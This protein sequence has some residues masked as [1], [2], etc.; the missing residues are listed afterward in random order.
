MHPTV[1][2]QAKVRDVKYSPEVQ[3]VATISKDG[4]LRLWDPE[5]NGVRA[6]GGCYLLGRKLVGAVL[7]F[8]LRFLERQLSLTTTHHFLCCRG[9]P[10]VWPSL[11]NK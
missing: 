10:V 6:V 8:I 1:L 5:L 2:L 9:G 4:N 3:R 11:Q 7:I